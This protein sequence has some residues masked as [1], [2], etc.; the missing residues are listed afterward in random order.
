MR[1][2]TVL[3]TRAATP[4]CTVQYTQSS[5]AYTDAQNMS[6]LDWIVEPAAHEISKIP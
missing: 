1:A 6:S 4:Y 5:L 2:V 3:I